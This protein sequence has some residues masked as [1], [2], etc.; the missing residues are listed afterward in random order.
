MMQAA[1][2]PKGSGR[3]EKKKWWCE[4]ISIFVLVGCCELLQTATYHVSP[5]GHAIVCR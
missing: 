1:G 2:M 3:R 4:Y 5:P